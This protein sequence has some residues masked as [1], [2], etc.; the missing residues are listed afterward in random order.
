MAAVR[1]AV[2]TI[3]TVMTVMTVMTE[4]MTFMAV[5]INA[6]QGRTGDKQPR[7][8]ELTVRKSRCLDIPWH[9]PRYTWGSCRRGS[10][11]NH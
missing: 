10:G 1:T 9:M 7:Q 6:W 11:T 8:E 4:V 3:K 2:R 5:M